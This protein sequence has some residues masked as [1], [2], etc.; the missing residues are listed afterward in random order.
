MSKSNFIAKFFKNINLFINKLL[1][2]NLNKLNSKNLISIIKSNKIFVT[3]VA[4]II[5]FLSYLSLPNIYNQND[6]VRELKSELFTKFKLNIF[7]S[8]KLNYNFLPRPHFSTD[9]TLLF[10]NENEI[11]KI[12]NLKIYFSLKNLFSLSNINISDIIFDGASFNLNKDNYDFF[13]NILDNNFLNT[14]LKL[15][16]SNIFYRSTDNEVL[17][18]NKIS[19]MKYYFDE[20]NLNNVL[21]SDN[22]IFNIPYSI[23]IFN[24]KDQK[25]IY[26]KL[27]INLLRLQVENQYSYKNETKIGFANLSFNNFKSIIHY[28]KNKNLFKFDYFDKKEDQ[29]FLYNGE[30]F[31]KPFYS[32]LKGNTDELNIFYLLNSN[33]IIPQLLKT[34][35]LNNKN[36]DFKL[37]INAKNINN[38]LNFENINIVSKIQDGLID[39][40]N[41]EFDWKDYAKFKLTDTLIFVKNGELVLD[42]KLHIDINN[43]SEIY[44]YLLTPKN[45]RK[46]FKKI[47]ISFSYNFDQRAT[48][49]SDIRIDGKYDPNVNSIMSDVV[50]KDNNLQNKIYLKNLLNDA[51]K[52]YSG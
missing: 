3:S 38:N 1:E 10:Y 37:N 6:I 48:Y 8:N 42:G 46:K 15:I 50:L 17:L 16:N 4:L 21:Y 41:T 33:S 45:Y 25:K 11:S 32:N 14:G 18:V 24:D 39:I 7:F 35:I 27:D 31:F 5:L 30:L 20:K 43:Y 49:L 23:K 26:T 12:K 29:K 9:G 34:E 36:I 19:E 22:E 51:I 2:K 47:N 13:I 52:S 44:K 40:D 28:K